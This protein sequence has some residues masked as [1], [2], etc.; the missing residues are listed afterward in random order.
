M[1]TRRNPNGLLPHFSADIP[2]VV[3][4]GM[5]SIIQQRRPEHDNLPKEVEPENNS[6]SDYSVLFELMK[7][8]EAA[9]DY[10]T[11]PG[12]TPPN[13]GRKG[14]EM[15]RDL[16]IKAIIDS[17]RIVSELITTSKGLPVHII[18]DNGETIRGQIVSSTNFSDGHWELEFKH[19]D[20]STTLTIYKTSEQLRNGYQAAISIESP[21]EF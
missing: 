20:S 9:H 7:S 6:E 19:E 16:V 11:L 5:H 17:K 3:W 1:E 18:E 12:I 14:W 2:K 8:T 13:F 15:E 21:E 10:L 4:R